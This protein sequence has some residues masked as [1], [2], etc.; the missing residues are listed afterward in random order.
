MKM[1]RSSVEVKKEQYREEHKKYR[2]DNKLDRG[3]I[4]KSQ[5]QMENI[6]PIFHYRGDNASGFEDND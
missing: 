1:K 6:G 2:H 5:V 3:R 4:V